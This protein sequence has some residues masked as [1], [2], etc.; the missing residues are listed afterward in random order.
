MKSTLIAS[1]PALVVLFGT[2]IWLPDIPPDSTECG[3]HRCQSVVT[4]HII[5][6]RKEYTQRMPA[7]VIMQSG[8]EMRRMI[9]CRFVT[10]ISTDAGN[11]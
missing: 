5:V 10:N 2:R 11:P 1:I 4:L 9:G 8:V 7:I 3:S 6:I